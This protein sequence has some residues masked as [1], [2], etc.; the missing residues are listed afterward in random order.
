MTIVSDD[1]DFDSTT[2]VSFSDDILTPPLTLVLSPKLVFVFSMV[3]PVGLDNS[4]AVEVEV[5]VT[6]TEGEGTETLSLI[7]LPGILEN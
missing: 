1:T 3:T 4:E 7:P 2:A 6:T 5:T